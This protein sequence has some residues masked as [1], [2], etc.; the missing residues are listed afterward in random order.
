MRCFSN[1]KSWPG[2]TLTGHRVQARSVLDA[3][4]GAGTPALSQALPPF[5]EC[6]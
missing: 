2:R 6:A 5:G 4:G 1:S 3:V